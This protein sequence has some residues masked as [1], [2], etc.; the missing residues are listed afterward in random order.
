VQSHR[1][2]WTSQVLRGCSQSCRRCGW[3]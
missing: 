3:L 2:W 1:L